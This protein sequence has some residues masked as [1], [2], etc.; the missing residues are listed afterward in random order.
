VFHSTYDFVRVFG[1]V[2]NQEFGNTAMRF[3]A[4]HNLRGP[5]LLFFLLDLSLVGFISDSPCAP[6]KTGEV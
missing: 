3:S 6:V 4:T 1:K 2:L 5:Q